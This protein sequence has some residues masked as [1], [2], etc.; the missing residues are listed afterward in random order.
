M[1]TL[2]NSE[3]K[4]LTCTNE[5]AETT[6]LQLNSSNNYYT[7]GN[8]GF[9]F[10]K[11]GSNKV[12]ILDCTCHMNR[13]IFQNYTIN[14]NTINDYIL[15]F[16]SNDTSNG[17]DLQSVYT[18][19]GFIGSI[20]EL[21]QVFLTIDD[22]AVSPHIYTGSENID[23]T[24]DRISINFLSKVNGEVV[25]SPRNYDGAVFEMSSGTGNFLFSTKHIPW[26]STNRTILF[27]YKGMYMSR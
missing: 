23:I 18:A 2:T 22:T 10:I 16:I 7:S 14:G 17:Y 27:I 5:L 9:I 13:N 15:E 21:Q 4:V 12:I 1:A 19:N 6:P 8:D 24:D 25:F 26:W 11:I 3:G 20:A